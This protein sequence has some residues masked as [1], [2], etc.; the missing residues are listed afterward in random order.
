LRNDIE[1]ELE[2]NVE[3]STMHQESFSAEM[4]VQSNFFGFFQKSFFQAL[5]VKL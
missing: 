4:G 3:E 5:S 2:E 1:K